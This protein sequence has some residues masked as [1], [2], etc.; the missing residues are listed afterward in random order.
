MGNAGLVSK[1]WFPR[2]ILPL[3]AIGAAL[4]HF[5]LQLAVLAGALVVFWYQ[6]SWSYLPLIVPALLVL[7][8]LGAAL[9][10]RAGRDQRVRPRHPAP[11]RAGAAGVVLDDADRVPVLAGEH[12]DDRRDP[13][14]NWAL[15]NPLTPIVITMQRAIWGNHVLAIATKTGTQNIY[16]LPDQSQWWYLGNARDRRGGLVRAAARSRAGSSAGSR[17]TS[18]RTSDGRRDRHRARLEALQA[19][20]RPG[21]LAQGAG[22]QLPE[23][24]L[25]GVLGAPGRDPR[26]STRA[27][28][29]GCSAT[30]ARGSRRCSS[31][32]PASCARPRARS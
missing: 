14:G 17:T 9:G 26:T 32:S 20:P 11:A 21:R 3:A 24:E 23:G 29:S 15:L 5:A 18:R 22:R 7:L 31:A 4:V 27:R 12:D 1:V 10:D 13:I 19:E 2:E 30:T 28:R 8:L 16:A 25:R 6:P